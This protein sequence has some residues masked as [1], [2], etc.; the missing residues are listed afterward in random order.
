MQLSK[1]NSIKKR[2]LKIIGLN[3]FLIFFITIF[4]HTSLIYIDKL[5]ILNN[6]NKGH[7]KNYQN[8]VT[9]LYR[10]FA[11]E[12]TDDYESFIFN[13]DRSINDG[14]NFLNYLERKKTTSTSVRLLN[15]LSSE[16]YIFKMTFTIQSSYNLVKE[17]KSYAEEYK[18]SN[19]KILKQKILTKL[20]RQEGQINNILKEFYTLTNKLKSWATDLIIKLFWILT[21]GASV[22]S[23]RLG[24]NVL[25]SIIEPIEAIKDVLSK[26]SVGNLVDIPYTENKDEITILY[27]SLD[28]LFQNEKDIIKHSKKIIEGDYSYEI[29]PRSKKDELSKVLSQMTITL[30]NSEKEHGTQV[31]LKNGLND[32]NIKTSGEQTLKGVSRRTLLFLGEYLKASSGAIFIFN[33]SKQNL[34]RYASYALSDNLQQTFELKEGLIGEVAFSKKPIVLKDLSEHEKYIT[35]GTMH[36]KASTLFITPL[37]YKDM[38]IGVIELTFLDDIQEKKELFIKETA[39]IIAPALYVTLQ[40]WELNKL[41]KITQN[42][43]KKLKL[44]ST[45][46]EEANKYKD[47][48]LS[49]VTHELKT[50]LNSIILLSKMLWQNKTANLSNDEIKK[51]EIIHNSGNE[52]LRLI[53]DLLDVSKVEAGESTLDIYNINSVNFLEEMRDIFEPIAQEKGL[54]F[55]T[56]NKYDQS[57]STDRNKLSQIIRNFISNAIKF[58]YKGSIEISIQKDPTSIDDRVLFAVKDSGIGIAKDKHNLIFEAF[59][60]ADGSINKKYGGTGLGLSI[61]KKFAKLLDGKIH[62]KSQEGIGSTFYLSIPANNTSNNVFK[63]EKIT[64]VAVE[65]QKIIQEKKPIKIT[66]EQKTNLH[67]NA[68]VIDNDAKS[69]FTISNILEN[70]N[71]TV[72][73]ALNSTMADDILSNNKIDISIIGISMSNKDS[74]R[75]I[76]QIRNN[77]KHEN[78]V[79]IATVD[80]NLPKD[81][82][83]SI[84]SKVDDIIL[85]P[86]DNELLIEKIQK[87]I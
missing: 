55:K 39:L 70:L 18:N 60:Q 28:R 17:Y 12:N 73:K 27:A 82:I 25:N 49:N 16:K 23:Y 69:I 72:F 3:I 51:A 24:K 52:L 62:L 2:L 75:L 79:I 19:D 15:T 46:L 47:E 1:N 80:T 40:R 43:N 34:E 9:E 83:K 63:E 74:L 67:L 59:K 76:D 66:K 21:I 30:K 33:T 10:F 11:T 68:M 54:I 44:Q 4:A 31:W 7:E 48:F 85:K 6:Y 5:Q 87:Y 64:K 14:R 22:I 61:S 81:K 36:K 42:T 56:V 20:S 53:E 41:L 65:K 84:E 86:I 29:K 57:F 32:L 50:P 26:A 45:R 13:I 58:T 78:P 77:P 37:I 35:S 71:I 8:A 38:L